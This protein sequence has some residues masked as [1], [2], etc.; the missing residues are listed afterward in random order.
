[1]FRREM[2]QRIICFEFLQ[3]SS[4]LCIYRSDQPTAAVP[5]VLSFTGEAETL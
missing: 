3:Q 1:M 2:P 4:A 5:V